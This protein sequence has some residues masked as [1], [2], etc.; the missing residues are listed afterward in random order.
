MEE[1][2]KRTEDKYIKLNFIR[3]VIVEG[4]GYVF[5]VHTSLKIT[6]ILPKCQSRS[7]NY[8]ACKRLFEMFMRFLISQKKEENLGS[9]RGKIVFIKEMLEF[10]VARTRSTVSTKN[11]V[12]GGELH[13]G[14]R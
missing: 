11:W 13:E 1:T 7:M 3:N 12:K 2:T 6:N 4:N 5:K 8:L 14:S 10:H 9:Q